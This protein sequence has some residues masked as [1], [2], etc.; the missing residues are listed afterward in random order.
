[1]ARSTLGALAQEFGDALDPL[2]LAFE[3]EDAFIGFMLS[4]GWNAT[5]TIQ[6]IQDLKG[7]VDGVSELIGDDGIDPARVGELVGRL[8]RVFSTVRGLST[9]SAGAVGASIDINEFRADFPRQLLDLL[10]VLHLQRRKP[11]IGRL[12]ELLGIISQRPIDQTATRPAYLRRRVDW[13]AFIRALRDPG[14]PFRDAYRF[15]ESM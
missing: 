11:K 13:R 14:A 9:I 5:G 6:P 12:L 15:G 4:L 3:D 7:L 2:R 10:V 8:D 1:M